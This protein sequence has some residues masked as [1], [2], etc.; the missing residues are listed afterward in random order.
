MRNEPGA[1]QG[2]HQRLVV[3]FRTEDVDHDE[4]GRQNG[5]EGKNPSVPPAQV[6]EKSC[7]Q[8]KERVPQAGLPHCLQRRPA[9]TDPQTD[10]EP[11]QRKKGHKVQCNRQSPYPDVAHDPAFFIEGRHRGSCCRQKYGCRSEPYKQVPCNHII[12]LF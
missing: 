1:L 10:D 4:H 12:Q 8:G 9:K 2:R 6:S 5:G 3:Y 7:S 11:G